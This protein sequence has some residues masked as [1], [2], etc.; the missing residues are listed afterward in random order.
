MTK[1]KDN[2]F[3]AG[4]LCD[5]CVAALDGTTGTARLRVEIPSAI[6]APRSL[7]LDPAAPPG[8][9]AGVSEGSTDV[10]ATA[11]TPGRIAIGGTATGTLSPAGDRDWFAMALEAGRTYVIS[12]AG[13]GASPLADPFL[14]LYG[15]NGVLLASDDDGGGGRNASITY[16]AASSGT[17]YAEAA[18]Y[19]DSLAG[20]YALAAAERQPPGPVASLRVEGGPRVP[21]GVVR[22]FFASQGQAFGGETSRGWLAQEIQQAMLALQQLTNVANLSFVRTEDA[23]SARFVLVANGKPGN[24]TL[25]WFNLP[26]GTATQTGWFNTAAP[27][28]DAP[29]LAQGGYGFATLIHEFGHGLGLEHPHESGNGTTAMPG[30]T[31]PSGSYGTAGLN[32]GI[33]TMM[34]YNDGWATGPMGVSQDN[35]WGWQATPMALDVA[36]LQQAYGVNTSYRAGADSYV[37]PTVEQTG[38]FWSCLWDAGG[39]DTIIQAGSAAAVIDLRPASLDYAAGGGGFPSYVTGIHGGFTIARGAIIENARGGAGGDTI[40]GNDAANTLEGGGGDDV[41]AGGLGD[42]TVDGGAGT[43]T[44]VIGYPRGTGYTVSGTAS[45]FTLTGAQGTDTY[46][47]IETIRFLDNTTMPVA[48]L[49]GTQAASVFGIAATAS[50]RPEGNRGGSTAYAFTITRTGTISQPA[51]IAWAAAGAGSAPASATDFIG[52]AFPAGTASFAA[53]EASRTITVAIAG[54]DAVEPE[55]GFAITLS[56]PSAGSSIATRSATGTIRNDDASLAIAAAG[57]APSS[58]LAHAEGQTGSTPFLFTVTRTGATNQASTANWAVAG[59]GTAA[60]SPGDFVGGAFPSGTVSFAAGE[61][62]R[63]ITVQVAPDP[64]FE[65]N[66]GF[67]VTLSAPSAGTSIGPATASGTIQNDDFFSVAIAA[68]S[69]AKAEGNAGSTAFTFTVTRSGATGQGSS[70]GWSVTGS[71][72]SPAS[73]SD[74]TGGAFPSGY[75]GF[76]TWETSRTITVMVAGDAVVERDE[77]FTVTLGSPSVGTAI[78]T[79][80]ASGTITNDD[81]SYSISTAS[82]AKPEGHGGSTAFTFSITRSGATGQAGAIGWSTAGSGTSQA[83][84]SDF[85]GGAFPFGTA[86]FGPGQTSTTITL[87]VAGDRAIERDETFRVSLGSAGSTSGTTIGTGTAI[88]TIQTDDFASTAANETLQGTAGNDVFLL[89]GGLDSVTGGVGQDLFLFQPAALGP[90]ASNATTLQ[91]FSRT[92]LEVINLSAID[93][94][95]GTGANDAFRFI[96]TAA[97]SAPGQLR[98]QN[99]GTGT[100]LIQGNVDTNMAADLTISVKTT[101]SP[102]YDWFVL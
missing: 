43:D 36:A 7:A 65:Q 32:Q 51:S 11:A 24:S 74:F 35:G 34:S 12:L 52:G 2:E 86:S 91:D 76:G 37:L 92:A 69:A 96:G 48:S 46:A 13:A 42:D 1:H 49:F 78:R 97:F 75:L 25:G 41:L 5:A 64:L 93:A 50:A 95:A 44:A 14:R 89:G 55:E 28:W 3:I 57:T 68:T 45:R 102:A 17:F 66:E 18:G 83:S 58:T 99:A 19:G 59:A 71:G 77:G 80:T 26:S 16:T 94:I 101:A 73:A 62:S 39:Q 67:T 61:T 27:G 72:A 70:V 38:T 6:D 87:L 23:A 9:P 31:G 47:G 33:F 40:T 60:A 10:P 63:S 56:A 90:A 82:A 8:P 29:G 84:A 100:V 30:V 21:D 53:G 15:P 85:V 54:D 88:F 81:S 22:V 98:W 20:G 4:C 79:A